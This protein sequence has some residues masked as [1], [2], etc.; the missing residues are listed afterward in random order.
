MSNTTKSRG[1]PSTKATRA[2]SRPTRVPMSG[3][4]L[5]MEIPEDER[6]DAFHYSW[7]SD[8]K[9][10]VQRAKQAGYEHVMQS[11]LPS[12]GALRDVDSADPTESAISMP[13]GH[14]VTGYL[15]KQPIE[16][17]EADQAE[18]QALND[19]READMKKSLNN[20]DEGQYGKVEIS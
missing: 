14:G 12:F 13:V 15:M 17:Y 7:I 10:F 20:G 1:R 8:E 4:R 19:A 3:K 2:T 16:Y 18:L 6:D 9:G 11:E 5:R